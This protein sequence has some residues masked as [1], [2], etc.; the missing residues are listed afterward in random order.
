MKKRSEKF[1]LPFYQ[2]RHFDDIVIR[3]GANGARNQAAM[4]YDSVL[5]AIATLIA[6][7]DT[8][9]PWLLWSAHRHSQPTQ[10][11]T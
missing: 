7:A 1:P 3:I 9:D 5:I 10:H 11:D 4:K 2:R 8:V 6:M